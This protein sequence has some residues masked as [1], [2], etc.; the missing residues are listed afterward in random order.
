[1]TNI[2]EILSPEELEELQAL[3]SLLS[4]WSKEL[5]TKDIYRYWLELLNRRLSEIFSVYKSPAGVDAV[6]LAY[7][8]KHYFDNVKEMYRKTDLERYKL[9]YRGWEILFYMSRADKGGLE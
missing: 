4:D 2:R 3:S 1:M 8:V 6:A 7:D 9:V 5:E